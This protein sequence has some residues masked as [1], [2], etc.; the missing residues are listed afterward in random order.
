MGVAMGFMVVGVYAV[1]SEIAFQLMELNHC[2]SRVFLTFPLSLQEY[3]G[4]EA[5]IEGSSRGDQGQENHSSP[6]DSSQYME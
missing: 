3:K 5:Q 1:L 6:A 2:L 4:I